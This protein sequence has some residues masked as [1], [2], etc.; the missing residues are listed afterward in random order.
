[1]NVSLLLFGRG[2]LA[3][4]SRRRKRRKWMIMRGGPHVAKVK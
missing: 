4:H 2:C 1:M 3:K